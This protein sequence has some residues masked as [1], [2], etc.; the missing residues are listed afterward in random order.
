MH[1]L[2]NLESSIV[3]YNSVI[4]LLLIIELEIYML[5]FNSIWIQRFFFFLNK[6]QIK[7]CYWMSFFDEIYSSLLI[8]N[9]FKQ[10]TIYSCILTVAQENPNILKRAVN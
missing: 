2:A 5:Y 1:F 7:D 3:E 8:S 9:H 6:K 4:L 10:A